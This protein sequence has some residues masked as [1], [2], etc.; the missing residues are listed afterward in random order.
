VGEHGPRDSRNCCDM[1]GVAAVSSAAK[2][3]VVMKALRGTGSRQACDGCHAWKR[4]H[5]YRARVSVTHDIQGPNQTDH[6][7]FRLTYIYVRPV[8]LTSG[9]TTTRPA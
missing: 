5:D 8:S 3:K 4:I 9:D 7:S 2:L 6:M 1:M